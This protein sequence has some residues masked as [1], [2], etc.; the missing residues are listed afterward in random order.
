VL[1][2]G[3]RKSRG[4]AKVEGEVA[5]APNSR[6]TGPV[7]CWA[8]FKSYD[9]GGDQNRQKTKNG[10]RKVFTGVTIVEPKVNPT[11]EKDRNRTEKRKEHHRKPINGDTKER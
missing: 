9:Q 4:R 6:E 2:A 10:K 7:K 1:L 11:G 8:Y 5:T 3:D